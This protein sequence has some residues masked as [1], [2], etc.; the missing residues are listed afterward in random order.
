[1]LFYWLNKKKNHVALRSSFCA[2]W[3]FRDNEKSWKLLFIIFITFCFASTDLNC[4]LP[5][6]LSVDAGLVYWMGPMQIFSPG[7][8]K[9][10]NK[11][12]EKLHASSGLTTRA[13]STSKMEKFLLDKSDLLLWRLGDVVSICRE[14]VGPKEMFEYLFRTQSSTTVAQTWLHG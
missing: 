2:F 5:N 13:L 4:I 12:F 3:R 10:L 1:M 11:Y 8:S 9:L 14:E 7:I 6:W